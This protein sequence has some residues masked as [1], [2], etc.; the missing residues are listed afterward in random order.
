M[1]KTREPE[2]RLGSPDLVR[3]QID[4]E[5][6]SRLGMVGIDLDYLRGK[7]LIIDLGAGDC[8]IEKSARQH[9][10]F[11]LASVDNNFS[12]HVHDYVL[13][14]HSC[15]AQELGFPDDSVDLMVSNSGPLFKDPNR[16]HATRMLMEIN[17]VLKPS[18]EAR[19]H[20]ARFAFITRELMGQYEDFCNLL[21]KQPWTRSPLDLQRLNVYLSEANALSAQFLEQMG[22]GFTVGTVSNIFDV[23]PHLQTFWVLKKSR[24]KL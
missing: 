6:R 7:G 13:N 19:I 4:L 22:I 24:I 15:D 14:L 10:I 23:Q 2:A 12:G 18:G 1:G 17:R 9:G 16:D 5:A 3:G 20:P 8:Y 11:S 21:A